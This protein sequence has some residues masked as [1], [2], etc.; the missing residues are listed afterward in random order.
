M[1]PRD[2]L[3]ILSPF[4]FHVWNMAGPGFSTLRQSLMLALTGQK[5]PKAKCGVNALETIL[6]EKLHPQGDCLNA[7]WLDMQ[8]KMQ[9]Q[10]R[11]TL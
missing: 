2:A 4:H 5:L 8:H 7:L 3:A 9:S 11:E 6:R 10:Y 1:I